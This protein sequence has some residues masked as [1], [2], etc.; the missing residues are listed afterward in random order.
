M[1][2]RIGYG[3][4]SLPSPRGL[5]TDPSSESSSKH[6]YVP[7]ACGG[8]RPH[9]VIRGARVIHT[10]GNAGRRRRPP[11]YAVAVC[12]AAAMTAA[13]TAAVT[14]VMRVIKPVT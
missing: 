11:R 10:V 12:S 13:V 2:L 4:G 14:A 6:L 5:L 8:L 1:S 7:G 9:A 3:S